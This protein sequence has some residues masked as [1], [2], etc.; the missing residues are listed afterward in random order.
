VSVL[1]GL[2]GIDGAEL[3]PDGVLVH[4]NGV[5]AAAVVAELVGAGIPVDLVTPN[6]RLEDAFLALITEAG[7]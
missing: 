1:T 2:S 7:S 3:H 6:R 5:P 4:P